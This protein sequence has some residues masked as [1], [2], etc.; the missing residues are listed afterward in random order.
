MLTESVE[1]A[2]GF[3]VDST[4]VADQRAQESSADSPQIETG[5]SQ[6]SERLLG[7]SQSVSFQAETWNT[8]SNTLMVATLKSQNDDDIT[9]GSIQSTDHSTFATSLRNPIT[10]V[11]PSA[12]GGASQNTSLRDDSVP[13]LHEAL[14]SSANADA[15]TATSKPV[16]KEQPAAPPSTPDQNGL[17]TSLN[18]PIVAADQLVALIQP[19]GALMATSQ[20]DTSGLNS[21][22]KAKPSS[23]SAIDGTGKGSDAASKTKG[24]N[25][26]SSSKSAASQSELAIQEVTSSRDKSHETLPLPGQSTTTTQMNTPDHTV[27]AAARALNTTIASPAQIAST[28]KDAAGHAAVNKE[29]ATPASVPLPQAAPI[30]NTA[31]LVQS[32]GQSEMRVGMRSDEFGNISISTSSTRDSISAQISLDHGELAKALAAHLPQFHERL[33]VHQAMDVRIDLS[34]QATGTS[35]GMSNGSA[36]QPYGGM[37]QSRSQS[38]DRSGFGTAQRPSSQ[39]VGLMRT[40]EGSLDARL[41]IRI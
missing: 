1:L 17:S 14:R 10:N 30:I 27:A 2:E 13:V 26:P 20:D 3:H 35:D 12:L 32:M 6:S 36:D 38:S 7:A 41:D 28:L 9:T 4:E 16:A 39:A 15:A 5:V 21:S 31:K 22:A 25:Q 40:S 24:F 33:G 19:N 18:V 8:T 29:N 23:A 37:R 11:V 34:G